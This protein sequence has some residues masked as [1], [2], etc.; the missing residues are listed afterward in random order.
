[1]DSLEQ[2]K[3]FSRELM[4]EGQSTHQILCDYLDRN[5]SLMTEY[6]ESPQSAADAWMMLFENTKLTVQQ[7]KNR[8]INDGSGDESQGKQLH[9]EPTGEPI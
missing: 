7:L 8:R 4:L 3:N 1:M 6:A 2:L 9:T 5:I